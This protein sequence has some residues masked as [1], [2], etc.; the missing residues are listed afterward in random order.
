LKPGFGPVFGPKKGIPPAFKYLVLRFLLVRNDPAPHK[1]VQV[2]GYATERIFL[3]KVGG[4]YIYIH[5][6][7]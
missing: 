6:L 3:R 5:R 2:L 4:G 1:C 7:L